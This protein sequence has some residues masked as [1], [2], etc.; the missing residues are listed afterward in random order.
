MKIKLVV[1]STADMT[2]E[3]A[4]RVGIVPLTVRFGR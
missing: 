4:A 2:P 1:D 3:V